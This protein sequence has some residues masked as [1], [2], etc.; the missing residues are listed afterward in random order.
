MEKN[1]PERG[2]QKQIVKQLSNLRM[3]ERQEWC[4]IDAS[5]LRKWKE[6]VHFDE[7]R[8]SAVDTTPC[9]PAIDNTS[10]LAGK[11]TYYNKPNIDPLP[12]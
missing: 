8:S 9:P 7:E 12:T 1:K 11:K 5:W 10:L 3:R 4:V 2:E 6:F